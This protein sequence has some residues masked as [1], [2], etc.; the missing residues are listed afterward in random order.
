MLIGKGLFLGLLL[1]G[2]YLIIG[3]VIDGKGDARVR[4]D[5]QKCRRDAAIQAHHTLQQHTRRTA[6]A[7]SRGGL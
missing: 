7:Q 6:Q 5:A 1:A 4:Q 3:L 2:P